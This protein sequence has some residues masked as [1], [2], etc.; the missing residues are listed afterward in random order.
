MLTEGTENEG[1]MH[2]HKQMLHNPYSSP[3]LEHDPVKKDEMGGGTHITRRGK[4][5]IAYRILFGKSDCH[6][7]G[8]NIQGG[9]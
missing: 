2:M 4:I 5:R 9:C 7:G 8:L 6:F 1:R 3:K